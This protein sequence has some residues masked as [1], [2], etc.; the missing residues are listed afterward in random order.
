MW[1]FYISKSWDEQSTRWP[2]ELLHFTFI[3]VLEK[4]QK[5]FLNI[6]GN[7]LP[8]FTS[9]EV[10]KLTKVLPITFFFVGNSNSKQK[11]ATCTVQKKKW[12]EQ[13]GIWKVRGSLNEWVD[14]S[15][16]GGLFD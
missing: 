8:I 16:F 13:K 4:S 5:L 12:K 1:L 11:I 14:I 2:T 9:S 10:S 3:Q 6:T 15:V 7:T